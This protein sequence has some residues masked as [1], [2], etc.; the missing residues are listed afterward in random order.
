MGV[1][2]QDLVSA[3]AIVIGDVMLDEYEHGVVSRISPEAPVPVFRREEKSFS[4]GGAANVALN[5]AALGCRVELFGAVAKDEA[6]DRLV[7]LLKEAKVRV[8]LGYGQT[9]HT[10]VKTRFVVGDK[11]LLRMD[12]DAR[13]VWDE[14]TKLLLLKD[15][16]RRISHADVVVLSDYDKGFLDA[17]VCR[18]IVDLTRRWQCPVIV[19]P[20]GRDYNKYRGAMIVKPN[21]NEFEQMAGMCIDFA[22]DGWKK[23]LAEMSRALCQRLDFGSMLITLGEKGMVFVSRKGKDV[24]TH[25]PSEVLSVYD[26]S[27]AGDTAL[28]ALAASVGAG[29][30]VLDACDLANRAAGLAVAKRGTAVVSAAELEISLCRRGQGK[31]VDV[32]TCVRLVTSFKKLGK[33]VGFTNGCFDCCHL[34]HL[35]SLQE[36]KRRCDILIVG[37]NSDNWIRRHK[38]NRRPI[39]D[40]AT[41]TAI[42]VALESV[43]FVV[44]FSSETALP[45][46]KRIKP[47]VIA[48]EGYALEDWPEGRYVQSIGGTAVALKRVEGY[49]TTGL[50]SRMGGV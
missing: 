1:G 31:V 21:L 25:F 23:H 5:L 10:T 19:D 49:S 29:R 3:K 38:G 44:V 28:A 20:K 27:G 41:R 2:I 34:G 11:H 42:L 15:L 17:A 37:V 7:R 18:G 26:V 43:D 8:R 32:N 46:V 16:A 22:S 14:R 35:S 12:E 50:M 9:S 4:A 39:Q 13:V 48:K 45:L 6:G 33:T 36:A 47:Q 24:G 30:D 40:E